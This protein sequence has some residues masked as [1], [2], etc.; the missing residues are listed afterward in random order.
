[1]NILLALILSISISASIDSTTLWIGNQTAM[2]L[3]AEVTNGEQV[4]FPQIEHQ[5]AD[6]VEVI[7][8]QPIDTLLQGNTTKYT[9]DIILT[10]FQDSLYYIDSLPF[11]SAGETIYANGVSLNVIQPFVIDTANSAIFDIKD[12]A[13]AP[14]WWWGIIRW[15]L[16]ALL[17]IGI[18]IGIWYLVRYLRQRQ[19]PEAE[20]IAPELLRPADE[21]ALEKLNQ[22]KED[23]IWQHGRTKD[24]YSDITDVL[25]EYISRVFE[26]GSVEMTSDEILSSLKKPLKGEEDTWKQLRRIFT[27]SDL[28]K[29]AKW[30]PLPDESES[31]VKEATQFV[32]ATRNRIV[33]E[34]PQDE[35]QQQSD[36]E[37]HDIQ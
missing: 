35:S 6:G 9:Q 13:N 25:R 28:V 4:T 30:S 36:Q 3:Q 24:Y 12:I 15:I 7:S 5:I 17:L 20:Q 37:N 18:G 2:H 19:Q 22:I 27:L 16:L 8:R 23:K 34:T 32:E 1:M 11:V 31:V 21:V 10:S 29:F 26:I 14:I 33:K